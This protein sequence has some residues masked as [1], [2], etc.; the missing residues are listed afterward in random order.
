MNQL[1]DRLQTVFKRY[2]S[3]LFAYLFGSY[4]T[5]EQTAMSDIDVAIYVKKESVFSFNELLMVHGDCCRTLKRNDVDILMLNT[6]KNLALLE[7]IISHGKII[8]NINQQSLDEFELRT[9]HTVYDF[10]ERHRREIIL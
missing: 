2:P 4:A 3:I 10:K 9:L 5:D 8:Y 6:T 7:E 1:Q